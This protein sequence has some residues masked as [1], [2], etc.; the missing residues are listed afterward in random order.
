MVRTSLCPSSILSIEQNLT[1]RH[2]CIHC[3]ENELLHWINEES[4]YVIIISMSDD[5]K[6]RLNV[7]TSKYC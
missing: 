2:V 3:A 1:G 7:V 6:F 5:N 4:F